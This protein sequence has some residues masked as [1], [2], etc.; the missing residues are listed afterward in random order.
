MSLD[1]RRLDKYLK[2]L[3]RAESSAF[4]E[5][6]SIIVAD[7]CNSCILT[8]DKVMNAVWEAKREAKEGSGKPKIY[9]PIATASKDKLNE[10]FQQYQMPNLEENEPNIFRIIESVQAYNGV[11]WL[12][13]LY[14]LAK[15]RH[16]DYPRISQAH[17]RSIGIGKGQN[18]HIE[19][20][21]FDESGNVNFKGYGINR[22]NGKI[23][24]G[25]IEFKD[26]VRS[27]LEGVAE[28]PYQYCSSSV[29]KVKRLVSELYKHIPC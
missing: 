1:R 27:V 6:Q 21:A 18:L 19:Y 29:V 4:S 5:D 22:E 13:A 10:K 2:D 26:E 7:I 16:E 20:L 3:K 24:P 8:L 15:I 28:E 14:E 23:E 12:P 11:K 25:R 9:F 17:Q